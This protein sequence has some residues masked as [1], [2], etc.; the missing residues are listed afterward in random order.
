VT[1]AA[2]DVTVSTD[3][4]EGM[5]V[6]NVRVNPP[7]KLDRLGLENNNLDDATDGAELGLSPIAVGVG[8]M[9]PSV[10]ELEEATGNTS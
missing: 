2:A 10:T 1:D 8:D 6:S 9:I 3:D 4:L 7:V 5:T